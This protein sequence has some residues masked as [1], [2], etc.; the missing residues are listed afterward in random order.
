MRPMSK[1]KRRIYFVLFFILFLLVTPLVILYALGYRF[2]FAQRVVVTERGGVYV[3]TSLPGTNIYLDGEL[4]E[5]TGIF[6]REYLSQSIRPGRYFVRAENEGYRS[7]E[8]Y[9]QVH[10]GRVTSVYPFLVPEIF[11]FEVV[12]EFIDSVSVGTSTPDQV[13][14]PLYDQYVLLFEDSLLALDTATTTAIDDEEDRVE[15]AIDESVLEEQVLRRAFGNIQVTYDSLEKRFYAESFSRGDFL[16]AYFCENE[17]CV[18][19]FAFLEV[20]SNVL[21]FDFYPGR[22]DVIVFAVEG[23]GVY[24]AELDKRPQQT[25]VELYVSSQ[26]DD[27]DFRLLGRDILVIRDGDAILTTELTR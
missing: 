20:T 13:S 18:N 24:A 22:D 23:G 6:R 16:P 15:P 1:T 27:V 17:Q 25:V 5:T 12:P 9:V 14:N 26:S 19:P 8:K 2:D 21:H 3:Y 7:W 10:A 4:K 11:D